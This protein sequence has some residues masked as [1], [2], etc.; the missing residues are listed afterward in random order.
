MEATSVWKADTIISLQPP[1][2]TGSPLADFYTLK[3]ERYVPP[4]RRLTQDLHSATSQ[5]TTF[6]IVTSMKASNLT[7]RRVFELNNNQHFH[8][9][10]FL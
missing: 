1:A 2:H 10:I 3:M 6:F 5:K 4:K 9:L 8:S 7:I